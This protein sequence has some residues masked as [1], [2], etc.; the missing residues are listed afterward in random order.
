MIIDYRRNRPEPDPILL[1]GSEVERVANYQCLGVLID[2]DLKW[3]DHIDYIV[4]RLKSRMYCLRKLY[5]FKVNTKILSAFYNSIVASVWML[6][7]N[8]LVRQYGTG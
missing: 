5:S 1:R 8:M 2:K 7:F 6:L 4:K 3:N